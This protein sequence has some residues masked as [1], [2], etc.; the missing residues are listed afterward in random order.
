[1]PRLLLDQSKKTQRVYLGRN[2]IIRVEQIST[3]RSVSYAVALDWGE[4]G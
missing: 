3:G 1:M 4:T 2:P